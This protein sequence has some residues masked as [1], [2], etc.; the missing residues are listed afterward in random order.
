VFSEFTVS[1]RNP[2]IAIVR[3]QDELVANRRQNVCVL[4]KWFS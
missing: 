1:G 2:V 3:R 4:L